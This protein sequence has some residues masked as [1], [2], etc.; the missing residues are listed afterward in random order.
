MT[1][2][3]GEPAGTLIAELEDALDRGRSFVERV[4]RGDA[5]G[6]IEIEDVAAEQLAA[7]VE[8]RDDAVGVGSQCLRADEQ[9][10]PMIGDRGTDRSLRFAVLR[11][12]VEMVHAP[13]QRELEPAPA[14][15]R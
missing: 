6:L 1:G 3:A 13:R 14:L 7:L 11:R 10:V 9:L 8:L 5:V 15:L 12:D 4:D 2:D